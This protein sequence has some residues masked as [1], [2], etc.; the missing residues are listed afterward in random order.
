MAREGRVD[1][2]LGLTDGWSKR[3]RLLAR[4]LCSFLYVCVYRRELTYTRP[5]PIRIGQPLLYSCIYHLTLLPLFFYFLLS[6]VPCFVFVREDGRNYLFYAQSR[7]ATGSPLGYE[8]KKGGLWWWSL[9]IFFFF[10]L[11]FSWWLQFFF[12]FTL[13]VVLILSRYS[14]PPFLFFS[15]FWKCNKKK[16]KSETIT[17]KMSSFFWGGTLINE[18]WHK[19]KII[20]NETLMS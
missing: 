17:M 20:K 3:S 12:F 11:F 6:F 4:L 16:K 5:Q 8:M 1:L 2:C 13:G 14:P 19:K 9:F 7:C 18:I 10:Y 15:N